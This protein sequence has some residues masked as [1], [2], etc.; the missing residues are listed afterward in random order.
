MSSKV[1]FFEVSALRYILADQAGHQYVSDAAGAPDK[2]LHLADSLPLGGHRVKP[3][4]MVIPGELVP[5][6]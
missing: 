2:G 6:G 1:R 5:Q 4:V 3:Q